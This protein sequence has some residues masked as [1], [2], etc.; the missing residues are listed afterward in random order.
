[1]KTLRVGTRGSRLAVAQTNQVVAALQ[2]RH[3]GLLCELVVIKTTGDRRQDVAIADIGTKGVFVKEI[4]EALLNRSIDFAIH[5]L[6]DMPSEFPPGLVLAAIPERQDP[7]DALLSKGQSLHDLPS[8]A[9]VGTSSPR[10][11]A[12][13]RAIRPDLKLVDLRGNLDTRISRLDA[14]E[15]AAIVLACAGLERL[16]WA[17]RITERLSPTV[18]VPAPGQGAL[19]LETREKD[20]ETRALLAALHDPDTGDAV[21][22]ERAFQ[23]A[24][25]AGCSVPAGA[26][27]YI[28]G[29]EICLLAMI[30]DSTDGQ[31]TRT[32]VRGMRDGADAVGAQAA[33]ALLQ[34]TK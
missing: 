12:Q 31:V 3:P 14:G 27:A 25:N 6:K 22:A 15:Y 13:L 24:L 18:C 21:R 7:R 11:Q 16:G 4:E 2:E 34:K 30:A 26:Y 28:E 8:G 17:N 20:E 10:R 9:A 5:S 1:M 33:S 32:E 19:A 23:A 29:N